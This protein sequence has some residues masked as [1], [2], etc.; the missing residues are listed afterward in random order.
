MARRPTVHIDFE[1]RSAVDLTKVGAHRY[2]EDETTEI[3]CLSYRIDDGEIQRWRPGV[4][5]PPTLEV[6][7]LQGATFTAHNAGFERAIWNALMPTRLKLA[8][9]QQD[10]TLARASALGLPAGLEALGAALNAAIQKDKDGHRL[11]MQM[12]K[13]RSREPLTWWEDDG[14]I[15]RLQAY[16]DRDVESECAIDGSL[17]RLSEREHRIWTLDQRINDRGVQ[18]D[19]QS[20]RRAIDVVGEAQRR[21]DRR[22]WELT[23]GAVQK[24]SQAARIVAWINSRG[25]PCKSIA[26]G[27]HEDLIADAG[28]IDD[29]M[30]IEVLRL[31]GASAKAFKFET[32]LACCCRD[33]RVR[34]SLQYHGAHTGRWTGRGVQFQNMKR[35]DEDDEPTVETTLATL[36]KPMRVSDQVDL[37]EMT[38]GDPLEALS[39]CTRAMVV[40]AP[41]CKLVGGDFTN[42]EGRINAWLAG[43]HWKTQA[44]KD[45]DAGTGP[46]LYRVMAGSILEKATGDV[47]KDDRQIWGKVPELAC[48]YQGGLKAFHKMGAKYGVRLEDKKV[49]Q[50]VRGWREANP[51]IVEFWQE[52]QDAA[53]E[54]VSAPGCVLT[55]RG[56]VKYRA[57][58]DF[59]YCQL[60]S[61]RVVAYAAPV[62]EYKT[63]EI[64][65]DG[66]IVEISRWGVSYR[67][68]HQGRFIKLDL[69][70]GAQCA[71]VVQGTA[72]DLLV[73][74]MFKV[75]NAGYPLVLTIHDE[76]L[77]EVRSDFGSAAEYAALMSQAEP[78][79][80]G[81]PIAVKAWEGPRYVK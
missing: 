26:E 81:L 79:A 73:D 64:T 41:G 54:A 49:M 23:N 14:R 37:L 74:A 9:Q 22:V 63:K 39:I 5:V 70:G 51:E 38:V 3:L 42:V 52:L 36:A 78:W 58:G 15:E 43:E 13:P 10:C 18:L 61:K 17:P 8:P 47:T 31:R 72:R 30:V 75:E 12:C 68:V 2:A 67:G 28:F 16:C 6:A 40:A 46:D 44:F 25:V 48:G 65:I 11:M 77:S 56:G 55:V 7:L 21:A 80:A 50:I 60:P 29:P 62:V 24:I 35:V 20:V 4:P 1:T 45:Y 59:L 66:E 34:G 33:G 57:E 69:Y 19:L 32:M 53:L 76:C 27:A 71:H